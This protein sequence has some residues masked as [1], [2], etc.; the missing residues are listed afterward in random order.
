LWIIFDYCARHDGKTITICRKTFPS[1]RATVMRDFLDILKKHN[2]YSEADHNK[3]NSEYNLKNNLIEFISLD[4]PQKVRGR[5]RQLL[6]INEANEINKED[7]QQLIFRTEEQVLLDY[8]PSD[9]YHFIYDEV[10]TRKDCD[11]YI[12]TYKDNPFSRP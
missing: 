2:I 5:K 3:S 7:W 1:L 11:F 8:N 6:Y 10:L 12:T 9:E 4:I